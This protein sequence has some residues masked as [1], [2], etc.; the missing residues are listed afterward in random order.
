MSPTSSSQPDRLSA[1]C[2]VSAVPLE[3]HQPMSPTAMTST[4]CPDPPR[5]GFRRAE[6][7][8]LLSPP[9][10]AAAIQASESRGRAGSRCRKSAPA[11]LNCWSSLSRRAT[12]PP[13]LSRMAPFSQ[14]TA[15]IAAGVVTAGAADRRRARG[16]TRTAG[17]G[18]VPPGLP[19]RGAGPA[20]GPPGRQCGRPRAGAR[21]H[22]RAAAL[23]ALHP[24][25]PQRAGPGS[26]SHLSL[27]DRVLE[28]KDTIA[29]VPASEVRW[30]RLLTIA[31][32]LI[33]S[34][35]LVGASFVWP[36][37][38]LPSTVTGRRRRCHSSP[39]PSRVR[40]P[41]V[42]AGEAGGG[43]ADRDARHRRAP[44]VPHRSRARTPRWIRP[45]CCCA[46]RAR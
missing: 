13:Q 43:R 10:H 32:V 9:P 44:A 16:G 12:F 31:G 15:P 24:Y 23:S 21:S 30:D 45:R 2:A 27:L 34:V 1:S 33:V 40:P 28:I 4:V 25:R 5:G 37:L 22:V 14:A 11:P 3:P 18:A 17:A 41:A 46:C 39:A 6:G 8:P 26:C 35:V 20:R 29:E 7:G 38:G 36:T 42:R 19:S